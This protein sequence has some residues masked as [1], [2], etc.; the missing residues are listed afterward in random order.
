MRTRKD[1]ESGKKDY[2][3]GMRWICEGYLIAPG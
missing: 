2:L 1:G 3:Y